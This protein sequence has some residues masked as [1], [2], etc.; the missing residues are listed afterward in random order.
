M[1]LGVLM[2]KEDPHSTDL[3]YCTATQVN[4]TAARPGR[5]MHTHAS[6]GVMGGN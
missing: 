5:P 6:V 4:D 2:S 1:N 3:Q